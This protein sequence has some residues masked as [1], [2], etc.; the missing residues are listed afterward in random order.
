MGEPV[1]GVFLRGQAYTTVVSPSMIQTA[2]KSQI[3]HSASIFDQAMQNVFGDRSLVLSLRANQDQQL[4]DDIMNTM[5]QD[6]F[7]RGTSEAITKL[8]Q[9]NLPNLVTSS[10]SPVDQLPWERDSSVV[11]SD[12]DESASDADLFALLQGFIGH[13]LTV[14]LMGESFM[15][16]FPSVLPQLWA[17]DDGVVALFVG[18]PK[19]VPSP[20]ASAA[21][22]ARGNL[23]HIFSVF[24]RAFCAWD[25]GIDPGIE[26][27]DLDDVSELLKERMRAFR[28][29]E[30]SPQASAAA[31]LSLHWELMEYIIKMTFWTLIHII[32][33]AELLKDI[34]KEMTPH[35]EATRRSRKETGFPFDEPP[36][37]KLDLEKLE[38]SCPLLNACYYEA[39]RLHSAGISYR[40]L[41]SDLTLVESKQEAMEPHTYKI[42]KGKKVIMPHGVFQNDAARFSNPDQYD[43]LR[44]ITTDSSSGTKKVNPEILGPVA[45]GL[46]GPKSNKFTHQ[47]ILAF[48]SSIISMWDIS[49]VNKK[50][51]P[52]PRH[53]KTWG[54]FRPA[55]DV[56][57]RIK[58]RV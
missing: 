12:K 4:S 22:V 36:K 17:F 52:I 5:T 45:A 35:A 2:L 34:R 49:S 20:M 53:R 14:A 58:S 44:F 30:L 18:S 27:R 19:W 29:L 57:A 15:E 33:D 46:Y 38:K 43:P 55:H 8:I 41:D 28:K 25:D 26:L 24:Y 3:T 1:F 56:S 40:E 21:R 51:L 13:H 10:I 54:T 47:T 9:D 7:L 6:K 32:S 23:L 31:I 39:I 48:T 50:E 16:S 11:L 37:L 42:P